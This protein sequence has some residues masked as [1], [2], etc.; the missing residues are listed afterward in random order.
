V[1]LVVFAVG[2]LYHRRRAR[3]LG[4]QPVAREE[5]GRGAKSSIR[6]DIFGVSSEPDLPSSPHMWAVTLEQLL[7]LRDLARKQAQSKGADFSMWTMR[8]VNE[9]ILKPFCSQ[10]ST[11][12]A[13]QHNGP[14]G[15]RAEVF[16]SHAWGEPF[17]L[18]VE[19]VAAAF[20]RDL[21]KPT[22]WIC[23]LALVQS[24]DAAVIAAQLGPPD[25]PLSQ[26][27]FV[28]ALHQCSR[29]LVARNPNDD[30]YT[31]M[32]CVCEIYFADQLGFVPKQTMVIGPDNFAGAESSCL[33][34]T[35]YD[36]GDRVRIM[37]AVLGEGR[38]K[39]D[40]VKRVDKLISRFR[41]FAPDKVTE[42]PPSRSRRVSHA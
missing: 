10:H 23:A 1:L 8:D 2:A 19:S 32:W 31:R 4:T 42:F 30:L 20:S 21:E 5:T 17:D 13:L 7:Q 11:S 24:D 29:F 25:A 22:L 14:A 9:E 34:A 26:S 40:R 18:F 28:R 41:S 36:V 39:L 27:P 6:T 3:L 37:S 33:D 12:W 38:D 35:C 16:V 15:L